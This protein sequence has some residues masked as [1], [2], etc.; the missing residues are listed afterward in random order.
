[1]KKIIIIFSTIALFL[2]LVGFGFYGFSKVIYNSCS[3]E[4]FNIDNI[5]LRTGINI[6]AIKSVAC[7]YDEI[8]KTKKSSFIIDTEKVNIE[9]YIQKNKLDKSEEENLYVKSNDN[10]SH[11]FKVILNKNTGKLD[12]EIKYKD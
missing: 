5:E 1:M 8:T 7:N 6:P 2:T 4:N 9:D 11:S 12:V 3:C 10:K